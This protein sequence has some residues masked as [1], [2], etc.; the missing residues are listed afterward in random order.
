MTE[1]KR[2]SRGKGVKDAMVHVNVRLPQKI[3]DH[4]KRFPSYTREIRRV[5]EEHVNGRYEEG[6]SQTAIKQLSDDWYGN[7]QGD[8]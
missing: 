7:P 4:F 5:L 3:V 6:V 2:R 8:D 1:G